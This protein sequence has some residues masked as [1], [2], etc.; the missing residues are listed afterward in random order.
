MININNNGLSTLEYAVL[1]IVVVAGFLAMQTYLRRSVNSN[2]KTNTD[3]FS[4]E[5]W[6]VDAN[7]RPLSTETSKYDKYD[8]DRGAA[9]VFQGTRINVVGSLN[10]ESLWNQKISAGITNIT[11]WGTY[12]GE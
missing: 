9:I 4:D 1:I 8:K 5:Q 10:G 12:S 11:G 2:W 6:A 7:G 3:M